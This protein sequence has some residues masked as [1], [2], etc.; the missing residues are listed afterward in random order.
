MNNYSE[1]VINNFFQTFYHERV[2]IVRTVG[3]QYYRQL[4][5]AL[6]TFWFSVIDFYGGIYYVGKHN[7]RETYRQTNLKLAHKKAF[8]EFIEEF[9]PETENEFGE[10]L[11]SVF[12]SGLVHQLSPKK[13]GLVWETDNSQLI[14]IKIDN[15]NTDELTNKV[16]TINIHRLEQLAYN[17]YLEFKKRAENGEIEGICENIY[18]QL[19][20]NTDGLEDGKVLN[21]QYL[22]L[23]TDIKDM[24]TEII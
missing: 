15:K 4:D 22:K 23:R 7:K 16:I 17:S 21:E 18:N 11:Y 13:G 14:W 10:L 12:R 24:I 5:I 8:I 6:L 3:K 19:I 2:E 9:F 20:K 1:H